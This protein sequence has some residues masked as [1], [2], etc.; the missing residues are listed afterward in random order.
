[1]ALLNYRVL[2]FEG[3]RD[4]KPPVSQNTS[5]TLNVSAMAS[6]ANINVR[7]HSTSLLANRFNANVIN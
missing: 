3:F 4:E 1:V 2:T 7:D 6:H 5:M